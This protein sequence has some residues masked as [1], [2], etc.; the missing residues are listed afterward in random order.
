MPCKN[1]C[2]ACGACFVCYAGGMNITKNIRIRLTEEQWTEL[3]LM[4]AENSNGNLT[5][6]VNCII[7]SQ[8]TKEAT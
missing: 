3:R 1:A 7:L 6:E 4:A 2:S 5:A 8:L